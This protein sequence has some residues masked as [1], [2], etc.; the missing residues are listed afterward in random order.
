MKMMFVKRTM[1]LL[2][3]SL[4]F[5]SGCS[6]NSDIES[7]TVFF[8]S[9]QINESLPAFD[10]YI[11]HFVGNERV[12]D[13]HF[14]HPFSP[15]VEP[16]RYGLIFADIELVVKKDGEIIQT[17]GDMYVDSSFNTF[18]WIYFQDFN[19][20]GYLD[21]QI[22]SHQAFSEGHMLY[23]YFFIWDT[24]IN[25]FALNQQLKEIGYAASIYA[26]AQTNKIEVWHRVLPN[27]TLTLYSYCDGVFVVQGDEYSQT[28]FIAQIAHLPINI[29]IN[30]NLP[31]FV[32][33]RFIGQVV[34]QWWEPRFDVRLE[35][36]CV[37]GELLQEIAGLVQGNHFAIT[38]D[39][40]IE[41]SEQFSELGLDDNYVH[42]SNYSFEFADLN[43]DGYLDMM[44]RS[45]RDNSGV[46]NILEQYFFLWDTESSIFV[47]NEQ[48]MEIGWGKF[49]VYANQ[50]TMQ[51]EAMGRDETHIHINFY[52]Y[53]DGVFERVR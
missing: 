2:G 46:G 49:D 26:N 29:Q 7:E 8:R 5:L 52:S 25:Q 10:F 53:S 34:D 30:E 6:Y 21:L 16:W 42:R 48:L 38:N 20:D 47:L 1:L 11:R 40:A 24:E 14:E 51:V 13:F 37:E 22:I 43:F 44:L 3:I 12:F 17:I 15:W 19:F 23:S 32:I 50:E 4:V 35:I 36:R 27:P 41:G 39:V 9:K 33:H 28:S 31:E 18:S 45:S